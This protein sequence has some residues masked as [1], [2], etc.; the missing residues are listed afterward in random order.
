MDNLVIPYTI[1]TYLKLVNL[2]AGIKGHGSLHN[3]TWCDISRDGLHLGNYNMCIS[4]LNTK[5]LRIID[6][7]E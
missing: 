7:E 6:F 5:C 1:V 2:L 4:I 3:C